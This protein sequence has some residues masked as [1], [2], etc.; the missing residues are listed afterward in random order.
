MDAASAASARPRVQ[1]SPQSARAPPPPD[2]TTGIGPNA[3]AHRQR[4]EQLARDGVNRIREGAPALERRRDV[5]DH[6]L[7]DAFL[8]VAARQLRG[9]AGGAESL[10]LHAFDDVPIANIEAG[11]D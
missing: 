8:V 11:D 7:V 5:E 9:I 3:A 10:E 2:A 1:T 4:N 6:Q